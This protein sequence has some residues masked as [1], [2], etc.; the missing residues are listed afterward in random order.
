MKK[1]KVTMVADFYRNGEKF[2]DFCCDGIGEADTSYDAVL[3]CASGFYTALSGYVE[4]VN[5]VFPTDDVKCHV[6][7]VREVKR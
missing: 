2:A 7:S 4:A 3:L 6:K 1:Y 5:N